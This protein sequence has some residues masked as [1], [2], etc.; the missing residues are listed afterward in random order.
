MKK[1]LTFALAAVA[2]LSF[3]ASAWCAEYTMRLSHQYPPAHQ[4][5][6]AL[7]QFAADVKAG[8]GGK[9]EVQLFGSEQLF[10]ANQNHAAVAR[11]QVD[12]AAI[13][14]FQ[15]GATIPEMS[16]TAIPFLISHAEQLKKFPT[17]DAAALL[18]RKIEEK[19]VHNIAWMV[20]AND[21]I[22]TSAKSL[23]V[24]PE[25][26]KGVKIRGLNKLFDAGLIAMGAAPSA[27]PGSE[28]YQA[29]QTGVID[30][31]FTGVAAAYSRRYYEVQKFGAASTIITAYS[32]LVVNPAW[33]DKL[34]PDL[35]NAVQAAAHKAEATLLP[36]TDEISPDD[37]KRLRDK[38]MNVVVLTRDQ[39]KALAAAMQPAVIKA[40]DS[41]SPDAPKLIEMVK[42]L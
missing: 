16:V 21:G 30:A 40:F 3:S 11:G 1:T 4:V 31:G 36:T 39:E 38:G 9:V 27:M 29:L 24:R 5:A 41:A 6:K 17:S 42:K 18:N 13:L 35:R 7:E 10:K 8:T 2:A 14:N 23:L 15:W 25:D 19:G 12:A 34:P 32:N 28:V 20:D 33:W 22:F 26:F 37:I